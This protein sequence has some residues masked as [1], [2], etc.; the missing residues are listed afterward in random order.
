MNPIRQYI[1]RA[2]ALAVGCTLATAASA[3]AYHYRN[4]LIG[5]RAAGLAGA[6]TAVSDDPS[7][8]FYNPAGV[9]YA[10]ERR[11][12]ASVNAYHTTST[13]Y[14]DVLGG[15]EWSR[16]SQALLP[17][18]FGIVQPLG[19]GYIGFSYAVTDSV[20]ENQDQRLTNVGQLSDF[21]IN[22][23][24][25]DNTYKL[26]ASYAREVNDRLS[27][28]ATLYFHM[29]D[30]ETVVNQTAILA[31]GRY[32]WQ[33]AYLQIT[34]YGF[35]PVLGVMWAPVDRWAFGASLRQVYL[36]SSD[37]RAQNTCV[38]DIPEACTSTT[39][40]YVV[41]EFSDER[42]YPLQVS[43]GAAYFPSDRLMYSADFVY[44]DE[45][46]GEVAAN[47]DSPFRTREATWN[48]SVGVEYYLRPEWALRSGVFTNR[49]NT[50][51]LESGRGDQPE[52]INLYG[53]SLTLTHFT[54]S[55]SVTGG[56]AYATGSG[57]A[58][59][60]AGD[61]DI[62]SAR[63]QQLTLFLSTSYNY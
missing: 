43:V 21:L 11:L 5:D 9:V 53:L 3:D 31:D 58:Q 45:A 41:N 49:A 13:T 61:T 2:A 44:Y 60:I 63:Q 19:D 42:Q 20:M 12:S 10:G 52:H 47:V 51:V 50:P 38:S 4:V 1:G 34:E 56:F 39:P 62:Q 14:S 29:R 54:R 33:N 32:A 55:S 6:Y 59:V 35:E 24:N 40:A 37:G 23:N 25:E 28:G 27:F 30:S 57:D 36:Y 16:E 7:G 46:E 18:F 48:A 22:V 15:G 8:L 17:N 26:G